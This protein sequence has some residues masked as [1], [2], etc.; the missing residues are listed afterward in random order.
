MK[1][2]IWAYKMGVRLSLK[3]GTLTGHMPMISLH[4]TPLFC[5][6]SLILM[7]MMMLL[8]EGSS[9]ERDQVYLHDFIR[10]IVD[11]FLYEVGWKLIDEIIDQVMD[12]D[13]DEDAS[14]L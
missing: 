2:N 13:N 3:I 5:L 9:P 12:E 4:A 1:P 14:N 11:N 8:F 10:S 6:P 7:T